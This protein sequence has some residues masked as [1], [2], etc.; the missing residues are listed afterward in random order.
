MAANHVNLRVPVELMA[1]FQD[2]IATGEGLAEAAVAI[3]TCP[4]EE[5]TV[6]HG[7]SGSRLRVEPKHPVSL[8][9]PQRT[10]TGDI[11]VPVVLRWF[12]VPK[13]TEARGTDEDAAELV[14]RLTELLP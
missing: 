10:L 12:K 4:V 7:P 2:A 11:S 14:R 13:L 3:S 9:W 8:L 5:V 6:F 1:A